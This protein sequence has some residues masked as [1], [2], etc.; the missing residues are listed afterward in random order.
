[1]CVYSCVY[2][3]IFSVS[4]PPLKAIDINS[5]II[6]YYLV[7]TEMSYM[8]GEEKVSILRV[9]RHSVPSAFMISLCFLN[10]DQKHEDFN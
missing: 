7:S 8:A 9:G 2:I 5:H 6:I 1:M 4:C 3:H 10:S